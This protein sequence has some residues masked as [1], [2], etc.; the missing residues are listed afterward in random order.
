MLFL[1]SFQKQVIFV[2]ICDFLFQ[3]EQSE[4]F[5]KQVNTILHQRSERE[6]LSVIIERIES[7]DVIEPNDECAKVSNSFFCIEIL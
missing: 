4:R 1:T 6:R 5:L 7:Y 3:I 2:I